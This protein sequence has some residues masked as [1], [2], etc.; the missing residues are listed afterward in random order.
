MWTILLL[1]WDHSENSTFL[2]LNVHKCAEKYKDMKDVENPL[3]NN[4][5]GMTETLTDTYTPPK[6]WF[7][8]CLMPK[9]SIHIRI[10]YCVKSISYVSV[11]I[12]K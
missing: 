7:A 6:M 5:L 8:C 2:L 1:A 9:I 11:I 3:C 10:S 12:T 4:Y